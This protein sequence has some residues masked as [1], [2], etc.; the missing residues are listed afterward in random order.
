VVIG[1]NSYIE[2]R[3]VL[4]QNAEIRDSWVAPDTFIGAL[5]QLHDSLAWGNLLINW[6]IDSSTLV[7]DSFLMS[8]LAEEKKPA[9]RAR[10]ETLPAE[11]LARPFAPVI[12]LVQKLQS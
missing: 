7:P 9:R 11:K 12:S 1:P 2:D 5:T 4:D 3:V 6:R 8:S 10:A